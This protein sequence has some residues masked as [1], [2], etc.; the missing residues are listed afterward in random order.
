M[1]RPRQKLT[2]AF[3]RSPITWIDDPKALLREKFRQRLLA[4]NRRHPV[5]QHD[6]LLLLGWSGWR[7]KFHNDVTLESG[8]EHISALSLDRERERLSFV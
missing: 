7:Q 5:A 8:S 6:K 3:P 1:G 2:V 4:R